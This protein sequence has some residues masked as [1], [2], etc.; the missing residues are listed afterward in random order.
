MDDPIV[1]KLMEG[2]P[3]K[4]RSTMTNLVTELRKAITDAF[5]PCSCRQSRLHEKHGVAKF[6][7][8][9]PEGDGVVGRI[10]SADGAVE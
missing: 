1:D 4:Y 10:T 7:G 6:D 2:F 9:S 8:A 5:P 3:E